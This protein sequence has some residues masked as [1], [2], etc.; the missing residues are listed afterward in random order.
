MRE[1]DLFDILENAE[2]DSM[3]R[4]IDK[5]PELSD[6]QLDRILAMSEKKFRKQMAQA[7]GTEREATIKMTKNESFRISKNF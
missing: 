4:L 3:E 7:E 5:C 1:K 6:E 2:N